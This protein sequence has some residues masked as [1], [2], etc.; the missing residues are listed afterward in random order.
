MAT[1]RMAFQIQKATD[2]DLTGRLRSRTHGSR[3]VG[4]AAEEAVSMM[5]PCKPREVRHFGS[6]KTS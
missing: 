2:R 3:T 1:K 6:H 5:L 4:F